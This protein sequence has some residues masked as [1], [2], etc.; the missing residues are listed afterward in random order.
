LPLLISLCTFSE[1]FAEETWFPGVIGMALAAVLLCHALQG[2]FD[3][4]TTP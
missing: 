3:V 4:L 1:E 2:D